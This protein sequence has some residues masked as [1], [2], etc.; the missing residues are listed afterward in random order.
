[1]VDFCEESKLDSRKEPPWVAPPQHPLAYHESLRESQ[2]TPPPASCSARP[3]ASCGRFARRKRRGIRTMFTADSA[4]WVSPHDAG[5]AYAAARLRVHPL[6]VPP[7]DERFRQPIYDSIAGVITNARA[8]TLSVQN[9]VYESREL[10]DAV[11]RIRSAARSRAPRDDGMLNTY[12][13]AA[14]EAQKAA[15]IAA[16][17]A[18]DGR[19]HDMVTQIYALHPRKRGLLSWAYEPKREEPLPTRR[20][21]DARPVVPPHTADDG[22]EAGAGVQRGA[23]ARG[24][25]VSQVSARPRSPSPA[26]ADRTAAFVGAPRPQSS[27]GAVE[28]G[29]GARLY[30]AQRCSSARR[31]PHSSR[32]RRGSPPRFTLVSPRDAE[33]AISPNRG[34]ILAPRGVSEPLTHPAAELHCG[35]SR[36][37][38]SAVT[39][40]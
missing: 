35:T 25:A 30:S 9:P 32:S 2:D 5:D 28:G 23:S 6:Q 20:S 31:R 24:A 4:G 36:H 1:M 12:T 8:T 38:C 14:Q 15:K 16:E 19:R 3:S 17:M 11:T 13:L 22:G 10:T 34:A 29:G 27:C 33:V 26:N 37:I 40:H 21:P 18:L 39:R 7:S